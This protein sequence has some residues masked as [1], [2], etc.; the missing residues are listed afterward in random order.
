ML[1]LICWADLGRFRLE[2]QRRQVDGL[3][4]YALSLSPKGKL[5]PYRLRQGLGLLRQQGVRQLLCPVDFQ[6]HDCLQEKGLRLYNPLPSLQTLGDGLALARLHRLGIAPQQ[7]NIALIGH[8]VT[9]S[10]EQ[11]ALS[12]SPL[13]RELSI[14]T[15]EGGQ[16]LESRLYRQYGIP[17]CPGRKNPSL[18]LCFHNYQG[19]NH[20]ATLDLQS[21]NS[22]DF[23]GISWKNRTIP[24]DISPL[25]WIG[26]LLETG[27]IGRG[28]LEFT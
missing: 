3:P 25:T 7:A 1:G 4:L 18:R 8:R 5:Y 24:G 20:P 15:Q 9:P 11:V 23:K 27:R 13:V 10:L 16:A 2:G 28:E 14:C 21:V 26:L 17:P 19:E 12:L 22:P 6:R